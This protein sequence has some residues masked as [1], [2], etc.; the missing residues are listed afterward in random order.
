MSLWKKVTSFLFEET[1]A[2]IIAE[3]DLEAI[4]L[5]EKEAKTVDKEPQNTPKQADLERVKKEQTPIK[6]ETRKFVSIDLETKKEPAKEVKQPKE[7]IKSR[8]VM[9]KEEKK[10]YEFTP[11][12][13]P[14]FG[15]K[16]ENAKAKTS[17]K[18]PN[19]NMPRARKRKENPLG[20][21]ISPYYGVNELEE[22]EEEAKKDIEEKAKSKQEEIIMTETRDELSSQEMPADLLQKVEEEEE[23]TLPLEAILADDDTDTEDLLQISLF[24]DSTPIKEAE[25]NIKDV[26]E[27]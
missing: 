21:I 13:S 8:P 19:V 10:E 2:D 4:S 22:F 24:G 16:E 7:T 1:E 5:K 20:T 23:H 14:I 26:T 11:V 18:T 27:K 9:K 17:T 15:A 3:D 25:S 6:Q 12:I